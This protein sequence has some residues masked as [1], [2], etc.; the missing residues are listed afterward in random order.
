[1]NEN[2]SYPNPILPQAKKSDKFAEAKVVS[3]QLYNHPFY[4][5]WK[6]VMLETAYCSNVTE[7][8]RTGAFKLLSAIERFAEMPD[9]DN[10]L[11]P[12]LYPQE[13]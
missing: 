4:D 2:P 12:D 10:G 3:T 8:E 1:M 6:L 5:K 7:S 13:E 11:D 9:E